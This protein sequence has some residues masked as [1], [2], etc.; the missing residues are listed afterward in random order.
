MRPDTD[1]G[2]ASRGSCYGW[3]GG[4]LR[5]P[6]PGSRAGLAPHTLPQAR[7]LYPRT[8]PAHPKVPGRFHTHPA[9]TAASF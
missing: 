5:P 1:L 6:E 2:L 8:L 3:P 4:R 9:R 7:A